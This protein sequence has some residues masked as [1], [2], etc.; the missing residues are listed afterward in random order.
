MFRLRPLNGKIMSNSRN[1]SRR[2]LLKW[3][4]ASPL[5]LNATILL[6]ESE[7]TKDPMV[8]NPGMDLN[9][10]YFIKDPADAINVFD[11]EIMAYKNVP[12]AHFGFMVSGIDDEVTLRENRQAFLKYQLLIFFF[13]KI[14]VIM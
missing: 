5:F 10:F 8:W 11:F 4:G 1:T 9:Q 2:E 14:T 3:L 13:F 7:L 6:T 12:V